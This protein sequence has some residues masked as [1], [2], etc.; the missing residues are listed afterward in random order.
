MNSIRNY[1]IVTLAYWS[2]MLSD[3]ALRMLTLLYFHNRGYSS[4]QLASLFLLY[5]FFGIISNLFGGWLGQR[6]GLKKTLVYGLL[7]QVVALTAL[8]FINPSWTLS[9]SV[10]Y[11]MLTQAVSGTAKDLTKMSSKTAIKFL[12]PK[13]EDNKLFKWTAV[14][15]GS[16]NAVKGAGFFFGGF[17]L[18]SLG[19]S[20][21]LQAMAG[22]IFI[23][24]LF[25][26]FSLPTEIGKSKVKMPFKGIFQQKSE[27][28]ILSAARTFLFAARD[29]WFVIAIP[30]FMNSVLGW[31]FTQTGTFMAIWVIVY[32]IVQASAP[33]ILRSK[34][35]TP[36]A[37]TAFKLILL[38]SLSMLA[39]CIAEY[40]QFQLKYSLLIGL[41]LFGAIFA[42]NSSVHSFLILDYSDHDKAAVN[43]GFYYMA[44]AVGRLLG[45]VLSGYLYQLHGLRAALWGALGSL[46][47]AAFFTD[48]VKNFRDS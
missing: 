35:K 6:Y 39:L 20:Q 44:N 41:Y 16:K 31:S 15:T 4:I 42:L 26:I 10:L 43:V 47:L 21:A 27:I 17:L 7:L 36:D 8:S 46:I 33:K 12:V 19:F 40:L 9:F 25:S 34:V 48:L 30:V 37:E 23:I 32:G 24:F 38:L 28:K 22:I 3:G 1:S 5:E 29:I 14:L 13:D 2:F 45:T 11:V 18:Q